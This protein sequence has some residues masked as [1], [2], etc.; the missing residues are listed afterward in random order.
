MER[1]PYEIK[2][3][4]RQYANVQI[5][6]KNMLEDIVN[7]FESYGVPQENLMACANPWGEEPQTEGLA[8]LNNCECDGLEDTI[9]D[10]ERMFLWF[11][12]R[13]NQ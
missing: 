4:L 11:V 3:K 2:Q 12:N 10:I 5:K 9:K 6:A 13:G 1:M 7:T 8:Y